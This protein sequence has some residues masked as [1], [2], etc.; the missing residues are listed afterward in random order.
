MENGSV[1]LKTNKRKG[2]YV[3]MK[4]DV[5]FENQGYTRLSKDRVTGLDDKIAKGIDGV[6]EKTGPPRKF[7]IGE[8]K[9]NTSR[10]GTT[11]DGNK[12]MSDPWIQSGNRLESAVGKDKAREIRKEKMLNPDNV[13]KALIRIK[14]NGATT[15]KVL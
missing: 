14:P 9:Y 1:K 8:A 10:L 11:K 7:V 6:Y 13:Q 2:N 3:E 12:Q 5:H 15:Q 4:M